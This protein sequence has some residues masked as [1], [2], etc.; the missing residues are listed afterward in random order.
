V[1]SSDQV[2]DGTASGPYREDDPVGPRSVL[3]T[4]CA[5]VERS[6]ADSASALIVR[7][8]PLFGFGQIDERA[9]PLACLLRSA[10]SGRPVRAAVDRI[11]SPTYLPH[12]VDVVLDLLIDRANGIWHVANEGAV[13]PADMVRAALVSLDLDPEVLQ[14]RTS[15]TS[16]QPQ[17]PVYTALTSARG[18]LLPALNE[19]LTNF[20]TVWATRK[21]AQQAA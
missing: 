4:V 11:E 16:G 12:L 17:R 7:T 3:G 6:L 8:G 2:F 5:S 18:R 15:L 20:L 21:R 10:S 14:P 1:L 9:D 19:S 13:S